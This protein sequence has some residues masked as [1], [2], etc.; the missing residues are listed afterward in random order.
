MEGEVR[1]ENE[2]LDKHLSLNSGSYLRL[3]VSDTGYGIEKNNLERIFEP[4]FTTK[5]L[6]EGTG[7]G[8]AVVHGIIKD[9]GGDI[10]VYSNVGKGTTFQ[11]FLPL[12]S[13][14]EKI[15]DN[16][17]N[18]TLPTGNERILFVDDEVHLCK[19]S[20]QILERRGYTVDIQTSPEEAISQF[21]QAAELYDL[22]II[23]RACPNFAYF[24]F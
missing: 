1:I 6:G 4:Y 2:R 21:K 14:K 15:V 19:I 7:L 18:T 22:V 11:V 13:I 3:T 17:K 23:D 9:D 24:K 10:T 20:K 16:T 8:L 5:T 12:I